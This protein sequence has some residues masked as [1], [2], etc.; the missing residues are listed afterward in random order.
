MK[1]YF[2]QLTMT[3]RKVFM[4]AI[5]TAVYTALINQVPFLHDTSFQDIAIYVDWWILFAV[6]IIVNCEKWSEAAIKCFVFF[7]ISQPLIY[8]IEVPFYAGGW[9]IFRYYDYWF[10][11]TLLTLPGAIIAFQLK[12]KN[13]LSV[14][15]LCVATTYLA[16]AA[17]DYAYAAIANFPHHVL[18]AVFAC[19]LAIFFIV[20]LLDDKKHRITALSLFA[21]AIV[22]FAIVTAPTK[23]AELDLEQGSWTYNIEHASIVE[24]DVIDGHHVTF[25]AKKDGTT[26][27]AFTDT[28]GTQRDYYVTVSGGGIWVD[29]FYED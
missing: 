3:W 24:V 5:V 29:A 18:S 9:D 1:K 27:V 7:L 11:V 28:D 21:V 6:F 14:A 13:W 17:V 8:V 19:S 22:S 20:V 15:V 4:L 10:Y 25:T 16:Y 12:K 2:G 26:L 23:T